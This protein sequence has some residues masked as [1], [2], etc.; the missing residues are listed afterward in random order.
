MGKGQTRPTSQKAGTFL[1]WKQ[2]GKDYL[3][4]PLILRYHFS[5]IFLLSS[6]K[7]KTFKEKK[8]KISLSEMEKWQQKPNN[9][10][11]MILSS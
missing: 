7:E 11:S 4:A 8:E 10:P 5:C 1:I 6:V 9:Q 2:S 3:S